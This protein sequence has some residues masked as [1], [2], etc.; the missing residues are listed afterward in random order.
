ML[1]TGGAG[2]IG[3]LTCVEVLKQ[4]WDAVILDSFVN[5]K[6]SVI[7]RIGEVAG[8]TPTVVRG[9][10][11]DAVVLDEV[12]SRYKVD[13][14]VH[15][16]GLKAVGESVV[17]PVSYYDTNVAG[18]LCLI[19]A[20]ERA[21][22]ASIVFSSSATVYQESDE[23]PVKESSALGPCH[24][25]GRTKLHVEEM[26]A[27][28]AEANPQRSVIALRYF[29]PVG[30]H[31]SGLLGEDP[32]G[33]PNNLMPFVAQVAVGRR[34]ELVVFGDDYATHDGTGVRDYLHVQDLAWG[35]VKALEQCV[36]RPGV[37][38]YNLGTGRGFSVLEVVGAF[39]AACGQPLRRRFGPRR[40]GDLPAYWADAELA[41]R[42]LGWSAQLS[43]DQ[44]C[45]DVWR[46]QL[47]NPSGYP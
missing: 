25:Y 27:D 26:L 33:V 11:R 22:I 41:R 23:Q 39:E 14:V 12:L 30:A 10:V 7:G 46:W 4:G 36:K 47:S 29:N 35:H 24:P 28:W 9:D 8:R 21:Q 13:A 6:P 31:P 15:F 38:V 3:S 16:A 5:S 32:S 42:E 1:L 40:A 44:I 20:M 18:S 37:R 43:L 2:Y 17:D 34:D 45:E 19:K